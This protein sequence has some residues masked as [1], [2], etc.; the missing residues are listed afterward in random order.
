MKES[1]IKLYT[2]KKKKK[3]TVKRSAIRERWGT[4]SA[5]Q[6]VA[7]AVQVGVSYI[8]CENCAGYGI[9]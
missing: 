5:S 3:K 9:S 4:F 7:S 6:L 8:A 1:S 2:L